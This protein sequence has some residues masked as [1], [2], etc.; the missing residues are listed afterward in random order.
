M[1]YEVF[2]DQ[3]YKITNPGIRAWTKQKLKETPEHFWTDP[4]S[5]SGKYHDGESR[6]EH[7]KRACVVGEHLITLY[8][9]IP[10]QADMARSA[11]LLH[12]C[13]SFND[14]GHVNPDHAELMA[15]LIRDENMGDI[16]ISAE[17][18]YYIAEAVENH[19]A[20][21]GMKT[22]DWRNSHLVTIVTILAD[23]LSTRKGITVEI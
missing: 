14:G 3:L 13:A 2:E 12:D 4:A 16:I 5:F 17:S 8:A 10:I 21:W 20:W 6:V 11:I 19:M 7:I 22:T 18:K 23:Y 9:L 1:G 15:E